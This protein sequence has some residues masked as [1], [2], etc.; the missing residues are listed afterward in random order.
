M[1]H[2]L[3]HIECRSPFLTPWRSPTLWGRLCWL[4]KSGVLDNW[5]I[6][7]WINAFMDSSPP[8]ILSDGLPIHAVL[9]PAVFLATA[10]AA[11]EIPKTLPWE[12]WLELCI[13]GEIPETE[14]NQRHEPKME[15]KVARQHIKMDRATGTTIEGALRT[16]RGDMPLDGILIMAQTDD[17]L[18]TESLKILFE[19]LCI[20]GWG[21]GRN[22]GYGQIALRSIEEFIRPPGTG[23]VVT[24][25]HCHPT[26]DLPRDGFWRLTGVPVL[27]HDTQTRHALLPW[28]FASMLSPGATFHADD[29]S[30]GKIISSLIDGNNNHLHNGLVPTLPVNLKENIYGI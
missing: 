6:D 3:I 20:E 27:V 14:K 21:Y 1:N 23:N 13:T 15:T 7:T 30:I 19:T 28:R 12:K 2:Y 9:T 17:S 4:V 16:E 22:Y 25:G 18:G 8:L 11:Q 26:D 24:L 29:L 10:D 5:T